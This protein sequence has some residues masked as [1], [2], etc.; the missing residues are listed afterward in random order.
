MFGAHCPAPPRSITRASGPGSE[1]GGFLFR[2]KDTGE[3]YRQ[4]V[5]SKPVRVAWHDVCLGLGTFVIGLAPLGAPRRPVALLYLGQ[6][7]LPTVIVY[8][9]VEVLGQPWH[10]SRKSRRD[11]DLV[12]VGPLGEA[13][14]AARRQALGSCRRLLWHYLLLL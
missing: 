2:V 6:Q 8:F 13:G 9:H 5:E 11:K 14:I 1:H 3:L 10:I 7:K 12:A 4:R